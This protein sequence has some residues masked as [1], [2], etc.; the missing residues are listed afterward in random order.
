MYIRFPKGN[1]ETWNF[2]I[3]Q[4]LPEVLNHILKELDPAVCR[5]IKALIGEEEPFERYSAD[6]TF[7]YDKQG[8]PI[9]VE[10]V[11]QYFVETFKTN[12][13]DEEAVKHDEQFILQYAKQIKGISIKKLSID[14]KQGLVSIQF[15]GKIGYVA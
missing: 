12:L 14:V 10:G 11:L 7:K 3:F 8:I 13:V 5:A 9:A 1:A 4:Y 6:Y 2:A 15:A